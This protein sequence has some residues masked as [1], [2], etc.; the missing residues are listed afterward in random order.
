M[1]Y[2]LKR[3]EYVPM[4]VSVSGVF[5]VVWK[6]LIVSSTIYVFNINFIN[7]IEKIIILLIIKDVK[8]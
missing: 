2:N 8:I 4:E 3:K 7:E 1:T 6:G 5:F